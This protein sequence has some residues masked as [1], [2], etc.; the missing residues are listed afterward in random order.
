[1]PAAAPRSSCSTSTLP[2]PPRTTSCRSV[3]R[4]CW[5][6]WYESLWK[7]Q[8]HAV[9]SRAAGRTDSGSRRSRDAPAVGLGRSRWQTLRLLFNFSSQVRTEPTDYVRSWSDLSVPNRAAAVRA[10]YQLPSEGTPA[11]QMFVANVGIDLG[12]VY[13]VRTALRRLWG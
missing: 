11:L 3:G 6:P 9:D 4:L 12:E 7:G 13:S 1:M 2:P 10:L 8:Q 5:T